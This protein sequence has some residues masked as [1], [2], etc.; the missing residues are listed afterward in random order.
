[1]QLLSFYAS[2][3]SPHGQHYDD[4]FEIFAAFSRFSKEICRISKKIRLKTGASGR[5]QGRL[6]H[7]CDSARCE[8]A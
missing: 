3:L 6:Y 8:L 7:F 5:F 2:A 4:N 1:M